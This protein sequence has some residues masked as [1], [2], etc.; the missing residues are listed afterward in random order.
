MTEFSSKRATASGFADWVFRETHPHYIDSR[1]D[2]ASRRE[3]LARGKRTHLDIELFLRHEWTKSY[4]GKNR[5]A[6]WSLYFCDNKQHPDRIFEASN[7]TIDDQPLKCVPDLVLV[8]DRSAEVLIIERK[9]TFVDEIRIPKAGWP[10]VEAQLWCYS[11]ID[12]FSDAPK[13]HLVGQLWTRMD[14]GVISLCHRHPAW[15]RG[16]QP[17]ESRCRQW[18]ENYGGKVSP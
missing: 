7:L 14:R 2:K 11:H 6:G 5:D 10:N 15:M 12:E 1:K 13:V 9:T 3:R 18:F 4:F 8:E 16:D 17:H